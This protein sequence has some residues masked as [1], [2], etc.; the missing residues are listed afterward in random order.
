MAHRSGLAFHLE[1]YVGRFGLIAVIGLL[2]AQP[3][4]SLW[5]DGQNQRQ[6]EGVTSRTVRIAGPKAGILFV[7]FIPRLYVIS[8]AVVKAAR[9]SLQRTDFAADG[10]VPGKLRSPLS[11]QTTAQP[12]NPAALKNVYNIS[13]ARGVLDSAS[14]A[15]GRGRGYGQAR[16]CCKFRQSKAYNSTYA[17]N[18]IIEHHLCAGRGRLHEKPLIEVNGQCR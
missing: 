9:K 14:T 1:Y 12:G 4:E 18:D 13:G 7:P 16:G 10:D 2:K 5:T 11:I 8:F 15:W 6:Q 3:L 17:S